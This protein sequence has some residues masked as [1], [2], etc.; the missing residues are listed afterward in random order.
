M[1]V[2]GQAME[3]ALDLALAHRH[4]CRTLRLVLLLRES[5]SASQKYRLLN[6]YDKIHNHCSQR[7]LHPLLRL[8]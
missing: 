1:L 5:A 8:Q 2:L 3:Q 4:I 7:E 6:A